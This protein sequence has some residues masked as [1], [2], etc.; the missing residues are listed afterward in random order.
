M[1]VQ[2]TEVS[3]VYGLATVCAALDAGLL[4]SSGPVRRVLVTSTNTAVPEATPS[5]EERLGFAVL[6]KRFDEVISW[7]DAIHPNHPW[8]WSPRPCDIPL[9]QR[10][11]SSSWGIGPEEPVSLVVESI[12]TSPGQAL[13]RVFS[14]SPIHVYA[15]GLMA[16]GPLRSRIPHQVL[17]RIE[18][19]VHPDLVPGLRPLVL[20]EAAFGH[21]TPAHRAIPHDALRSVFAELART[22][23]AADVVAPL[24]GGEAPAVILGQY[25]SAAGIISAQEEDRL[26]LRMLRQAAEAGHRHVVFKA[27]PSAPGTQTEALCKSAADLGVEFRSTTAPVPA[28]VLFQ[29]VRPSAVIGCFSTG[30]FTARTLYGIPAFRVGTETVLSGLRP[31]SNSNRIPLAIAYAGLSSPSLP[32]HNKDRGGA[33]VGGDDPG[34]LVRTLTYCMHPQAYPQ[35]RRDAE[36]FLA[37]HKGSAVVRRN[38]GLGRLTRLRLPGG[39]PIGPLGDRLLTSHRL[40]PAL[41]RAWRSYRN[42]RRRVPLS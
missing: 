33:P 25:L 15:D 5:W 10:V 18:D 35:L 38:V 37:Q 29:E 28:E 13:A 30:L 8:D 16:Y 3:T 32:P 26:H 42:L 17:Q 22:R 12:Q 14:D 21:S 7:N 20:D 19:L 6:R 11:L 24:R 9:L 34:P 41:R 31:Y 39:L 23:E 2:I 36:Q 4:A 27:H 1:T 40:S